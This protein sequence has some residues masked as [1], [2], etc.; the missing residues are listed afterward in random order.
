MRACFLYLRKKHLLQ[1][2]IKKTIK[3]SNIDLTW[4]LLAQYFVPKSIIAPIILQFLDARAYF[5]L[6]TRIINYLL[7]LKNNQITKSR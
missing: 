7:H 1:I 4:S 5:G 6:F 3:P 2:L